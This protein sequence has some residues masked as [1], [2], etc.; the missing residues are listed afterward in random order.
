LQEGTETAFFKIDGFSIS[1][2]TADLSARTLSAG[3]IKLDRPTINANRNEAGQINLAQLIPMAHSPSSNETTQATDPE[4]ERAKPWEWTVEDFSISEGTVIW[5]D[6]AFSPAEVHQVHLSLVNAQSITS[7][8]A[9]EFPISL[10]ARL[11][12][13]GALHIQGQVAPAPLQANLSI[14]LEGFDPGRLG[15]YWSPSARLEWHRGTF[16]TNTAVNVSTNTQDTLELRTQSD[17]KIRDLLLHEPQ[18][19][20]NLISGS[21]L[22]V[23]DAHFDLTER[24]LQIDRILLDGMA[25]N[26][27]RDQNGALNLPTTP[28]NSS[29]SKTSKTNGES[30]GDPPKSTGLEVSIAKLQIVENQIRFN[31]ASTAPAVALRLENV[32]GHILNIDSDPL[33]RAELDLSARLQGVSTL[34]IAGSLNPFPETLFIDLKTALE[35]TD[36]TLFSPYTAQML[37]RSIAKGKL[38]LELDQ[39]IEDRHLKAKT[40]LRLDQFE[41]GGKVDAPGAPSLPLDLAVTLFKDTRGVINLPIPVEGNLD[42]PDFSY[43]ALVLQALGNLIVKATT[44]P[45]RFLAGSLLPKGIDPELLGF[46]AGQAE[47]SPDNPTIAGLVTMYQARPELTLELRGQFSP[48]DVDFLKRAELQAAIEAARSGF[49]QEGQSAATAPRNAILRKM[50]GQSGEVEIDEIEADLLAQITVPAAQLITLAQRRSEAAQAALIAAGIPS[51]AVY[52]LEAE[53]KPQSASGVRISIPR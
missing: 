19:G 48:Q 42:D 2:I 47:T 8:L 30:S 40:V 25:F 50:S 31:D 13:A 5:T 32:G 4:R 9:R 43:G 6:N 18:S 44:A 28:P 46:A 29:E 24:R 1:D 23:A 35:T 37:G 38:S 49:E 34:H 52:L 26:L 20:K 53:N 7:D 36:L 39:H 10:A 27:Q 17:L 51:E 11:A 21:L 3:S 16:S 12:D 45:L 22:E 33:A 41:W 14:H 15:A